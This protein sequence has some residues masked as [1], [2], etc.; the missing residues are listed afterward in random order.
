MTHQSARKSQRKPRP[1]PSPQLPI[2][3]PSR[4]HLKRRNELP[5]ILDATECM[6]GW[7]VSVPCKMGA[8]CRQTAKDGGQ[9]GARAILQT[10]HSFSVNFEPGG[11]NSCLPN[12]C[13]RTHLIY[14]PESEALRFVLLA[15]TAKTSG[16]AR[17]VAGVAAKGKRQLVSLPYGRLGHARQIASA[18]LGVKRGLG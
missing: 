13:E 6:I 14:S 15:R 7:V 1:A 18:M 11:C 12:Q 3:S 9:S 8:A 4:G 2:E 5:G 17:S 16:D 10:K